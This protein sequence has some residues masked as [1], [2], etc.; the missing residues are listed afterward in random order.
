MSGGVLITGIAI[1]L[2]LDFTIRNY[3]YMTSDPPVITLLFAG[4]SMIAAHFWGK[5]DTRKED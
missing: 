1:G 2:L 4:L 3:G 5:D